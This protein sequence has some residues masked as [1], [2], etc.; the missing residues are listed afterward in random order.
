MLEKLE[1]TNFQGH[2]HSVLEF[3]KGVNVI[4][5]ESDEGKSSIIRAIEYLGLNSPSKNN[6]KN[7]KCKDKDLMQIAGTF[8]GTLVKRLKSKTINQYQINDE[9]PFKAIKTEL[10][11][12]VQQIMNL[13]DINIQSQS[14]AY[15]MLNLTPGQ[16]AKKINKVVNLEVMHKVLSGTKTD[17]TDAKQNVLFWTTKKDEYIKEVKD[18]TWVIEARKQ[19]DALQNSAEVIIKEIKRYNTG[20]TIAQGY[21]QL[22]AEKEKFKDL[23][24]AMNALKKLE[25][26]Q[27]LLDEKIHKYDTLV[28]LADSAVNLKAQLNAYKGIQKAQKQLNALL[29]LTE[30]IETANNVRELLILCIN[31]QTKIKNATKDVA[32]EQKV[33]AEALKTEGVCP[34]CE[35]KIK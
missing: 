32:V 35:Q 1:L 20:D 8:N 33:F 10:P 34:F 4:I 21:D 27:R 7:R 12:E 13:K 18:L 29:S 2:I 24:L 5:G 25:G 16:V 30:E 22:C 19:G 23:K 28:T 6:Y 31:N 17:I 14:D 3:S 11:N 15:F 26:Q 9:K